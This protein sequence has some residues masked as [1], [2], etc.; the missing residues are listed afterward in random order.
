MALI[1]HPFGRYQIIDRE[2]YRNHWVK[3]NDLKRIIEDELGISVSE[4]TITNDINAMRDDSLLGY[5]APIEYN[6]SE[7]AHYYTDRKYTIKAFGL[8]DADINA[9]KFYANTLKQYTEYEVFKDFS[10]AIQKVLDA[11]KIRSGIRNLDRAKSVVQTEQVPRLT[12]SDRIPVIIQA[13]NENKKLYFEYKKFE[14]LESKFVTLEP[15]LLKEDR[16]R[17]YIV[18]K[19]EKYDEPTTTYAL[20]RILNIRILDD[21]FVPTEFDFNQYYTHS[22]GITVPKHKAIDVILSFTPFQGMYLKTLKIHSSQ[23]VIIDNDKEFRISIKV[24]PSWEFYSIVL[25]YG[26]SVKVLAPDSIII[27]M[28][29]RIELMSKSYS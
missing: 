8:K 12:G 25:G 9:L 18:G 14:D 19:L 20:D 5:L 29:N 7:K 13:L 6:N 10:N 26:T 24:K 28:K 27:E 4:K 16:H 15:H 17:W 11:V 1:K 2:L 23:T 3:T 21:K 22:F